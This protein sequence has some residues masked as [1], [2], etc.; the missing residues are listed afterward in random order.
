MLMVGL[1]ELTKQGGAN[2]NEISQDTM[3]LDQNSL[4]MGLG[5][6]KSLLEF[7]S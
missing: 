6:V 3:E 5:Q 4:F 7:L 2:T 1:S